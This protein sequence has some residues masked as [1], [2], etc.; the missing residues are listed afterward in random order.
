MERA[1]EHRRGPRADFGLRQ[2]R[3][4]RPRR[5]R[6]LH[7]RP[8][9]RGRGGRRRQGGRGHLGALDAHLHHQRQA[10][11]RRQPAADAGAQPHRERAQK[12]TKDHSAVAART[13]VGLILLASGVHKLFGAP[14]EFAAV[15]EKYQIIGG[16]GALLAAARMMPLAEVLL[17][18]A[19]LL[20]W[21]VRWAAAGAASLFGL[22]LTALASTKLRGIPLEDC[23]CFGKGIHLA[24]HWTMALDSLLIALSYWGWTRPTAGAWLDAW[25]ERGTP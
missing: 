21:R 20:G 7:G 11:R 19:L 10:L 3:R 14:E 23:G 16:E 9:R 12:V 25:V 8:R 17:G 24:P 15:I 2:G 18:L 4:A 1:R 13:L 6:L 22:F 5:P